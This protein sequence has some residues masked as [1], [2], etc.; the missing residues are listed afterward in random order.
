[1]FWFYNNNFK[2]AGAYMGWYYLLDNKGL[3]YYNGNSILTGLSMVS[4]SVALVLFAHGVIL[5]MKTITQ[6]KWKRLFS[7]I[8][9]RVL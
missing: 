1:M 8:I 6:F 4:L 5:V 9:Q 7:I 3:N 2:L